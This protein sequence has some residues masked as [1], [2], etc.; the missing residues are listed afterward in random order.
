MFAVALEMI[1]CL[2]I[3]AVLGFFIGYYFCKKQHENGNHGCIFS[4]LFKKEVKSE[5]ETKEVKKDD[6]VHLFDEAQKPN[7]FTD[8]SGEKDDLK[9]IKGIGVKIEEALNNLGVY[10]F[11]QIASWS[12]ENIAWIDEYLVFKGRVQRENWV[13]Q[14]QTLEKGEETEFSKRYNEKH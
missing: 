1:I 14:A 4:N 10:K 12:E 11:S 13:S 2:L 3:A 6:E 8:F 5:N 9:K 7:F